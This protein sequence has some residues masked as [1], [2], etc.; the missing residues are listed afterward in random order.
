MSNK[1]IRDAIETKL[2]TL[3]GSVPIAWENRPYTPTI[4]TPYL[5]ATYMPASTQN[6]SYGA[7][8]K[9]ETGTYRVNICFPTRNGTAAA[10][11]WAETLRD[12]FKRGTTLTDSGVTVRILRDPYIAP[13]ISQPDWY[14]I[15][16]MIP[17]QAD[18][19]T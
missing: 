6:P 19:L 15:P 10:T 7:V 5:M 9:R 3:A 18:V 8:H 12:G 16:C 11:N 1:L 2:K 14:V 13:G 4:G 17:Y